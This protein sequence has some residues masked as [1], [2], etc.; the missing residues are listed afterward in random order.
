MKLAAS[1]V[2]FRAGCVVGAEVV[3]VVPDVVAVVEAVE[4]EGGVVV[5]AVELVGNGVAVGTVQNSVLFTTLQS[6]TVELS[7]Q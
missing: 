1:N 6:L 5:L 2:D 3:L 7:E 4:G